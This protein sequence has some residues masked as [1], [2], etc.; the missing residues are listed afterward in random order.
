MN[1]KVPDHYIFEVERIAE[2]QF[3]V[4]LVDAITGERIWC[5]MTSDPDKVKDEIYE[6][7]ER[8]RKC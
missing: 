3:I 4:V 7:R 2:M 8:Q 5:T 1:I 6:L